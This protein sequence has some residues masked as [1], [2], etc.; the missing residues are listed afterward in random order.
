MSKRKTFFLFW[1]ALLLLAPLLRAETLLPFISGEKLEYEMKWGFFPV[2]YA[3]MEVNRLSGDDGN[4]SAMGPVNQVR[5]FVRT[6]SFADTF[7]KVRTTITSTMD[8]AFTRTLS[9]QKSQR[10]GSTRR[11]ILVDYDYRKKEVRYS[12]NGEDPKTM[13]LPEPCFDPLAIAYYFRIHP[14]EPNSEKVLPTCDGKKFRRVVVRSGAREKLKL[15]MGTYSAIR[16]EPAMEN[17]G[18]IFNKSPDGLLQ[19][20]YSADHRRVPV[21][22]S[23]KVVVGSFTATLTR[24][25]PPLEKNF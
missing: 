21:R 12:L 17:L 8:D 25:S 3:T 19:V 13:P 22:V 4:H 7:Y 9:Y 1:S 14:I 11:E 15:P 18:G 5:F 24:A 16:T 2:G 20:W 6:N 23:S 10:E